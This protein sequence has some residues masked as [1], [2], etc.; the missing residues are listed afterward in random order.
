MKKIILRTGVLLCFTVYVFSWA[1]SVDF[2]TLDKISLEGSDI[3]MTLSGET[4][5]HVFKISNP[6]RI[7]VE[8]SNTEINVKD[9]EIEGPGDPIK[10]V[11]SGQ[12]QNEPVKIVRIV[13]DLKKM[14]EYELSSNNNVVTLTLN[15]DEAKEQ[16]SLPG[17]D[18]E[19]IVAVPYDE[20]TQTKAEAET[21]KKPAEAPGFESEKSAVMED[22]QKEAKSAAA[23]AAT[24]K[25]APKK[26]TKKASKDAKKE[27]QKKAETKKLVLPKKPIDVDFEEADIRDVFRILSVKSGIN[28]IYGDDVTGNITLRLDNVPFDKAFDTILSLK[29][30]VS[31]EVDV[32]ILRVSTPQKISEQRAQAVTFTKIYPLN[33]ANSEEVKSNLDT[34]RTAEGRRGNISVDQRTNSLIVTDTP[35]GLNS[36]EK[37]ILELDKKPAQVII[38]AK[39]VEVVL[40]KESD[41]GIQWQYAATITNEPNNQVYLGSTHSE[42]SDDALGTSASPGATVISPLSPAQGGTGVSLPASAVSGQIGAISFGIVANDTLITGVLNALAQKGLSKLLSNPKVTTI[43]NK[44]AKI[45]IGQRIPYTTTTVTNTG[46]TQNTSFLDVGVKLTVKPTI[47]VDQKITLDVH[48]EVSLFVRADPAG[49]VIGTREAQTTVLVSNGETVVIGG[50]ITEEDRKLGTQVPLLGDIPIIGHLFRRDYKSKQK[51]ELLVFLTPQIINN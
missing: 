7:V 30:L 49:P 9:R 11:R 37:I 18:A 45:L 47:N 6:P 35:E 44:E 48:P 32:N 15:P 3:V 51:T 23:P 43:N 1:Q 29:G 12:F 19:T 17:T 16:E 5:S 33:Y 21:V 46:S 26:A 20:T 50:L 10:R 34:V 22:K 2:K 36:V 27:E 28:I 13:V 39:I 31:Q 40:N 41:L 14:V 42:T 25:K 38:E 4:R 8:L 24:A